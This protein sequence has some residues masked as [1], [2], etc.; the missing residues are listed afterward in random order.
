MGRIE[1]HRSKF[2]H[3]GERSHIDDQIVVAKTDTALGEKDLRVA[4]IAALLHRMPHVPGRIE[5]PLLYIHSASAQ[6]RGDNQIGLPAEKCRYLQNIGHFGDFADVCRFMHV[7]QYWHIEFNFNLF[8]NAQTF[9]QSWP[10]KAADGSAVRL[11]ITGFENE[12]KLEGSR[13]AFDDLC[14]ADRVFFALNHARAGDEEQV[15]GSDLNVADLE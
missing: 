14:H 7:G 8:Q 6:C 11:V 4:G 9:L 3:D 5:L 12:R 2:A 10:A 1:N 15:A 13:H